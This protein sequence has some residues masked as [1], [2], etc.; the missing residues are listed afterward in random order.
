MSAGDG[1]EQTTALAGLDGH[2]DDQVLQLRADLLGL[3]LG[4]DLLGLAG[5]GDV[6]DLG[7]S[8]ARPL[9]GVVLRQQKVTAVT[10]LDLNDVTGDTELGHRSSENELHVFLPS[11]RAV[12][13][14]GSSASS[15]A[16]LIAMATLR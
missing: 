15:R 1:T 8:T 9:D 7:L 14:Y 12:E 5:A 3:L 6:L 16:F 10:V 2:L 13:A 4:V 11:Q